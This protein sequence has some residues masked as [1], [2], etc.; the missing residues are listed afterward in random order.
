VTKCALCSGPLLYT[1][2]L[3]LKK[4]VLFSWKNVAQIAYRRFPAFT[5]LHNICF[6]AFNTLPDPNNINYIKANFKPMPRASP[7]FSF[8]IVKRRMREISTNR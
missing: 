2:F 7:V 8:K 6:S 5:F 4:I 1:E 3:A